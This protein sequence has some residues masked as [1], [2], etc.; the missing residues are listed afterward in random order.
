M[1]FKTIL[2]KI[3]VWLI[4]LAGVAISVLVVIA[5]RTMKE[6]SRLKARVQNAEAKINHA[7]V[8]AQEDTNAIQNE[9]I[10]EIEIANDLER[11][12]RS[13]NPNELFDD[14]DRS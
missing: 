4:A 1:V 6:N 11:E 7:R 10:R 2:S 12:R 14:E 13:W 5:N 9:Q 3:W 8:V